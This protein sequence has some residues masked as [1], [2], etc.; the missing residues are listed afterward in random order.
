MVRY[1]FIKPKLKTDWQ[2]I[3]YD[4]EGRILLQAYNKSKQTNKHY[5]KM[6]EQYVQFIG[7]LNDQ[8]KSYF[9]QK[10]E[11]K[12]YIN[13][14]QDQLEDFY[15]QYDGVYDKYIQM[16]KQI[17]MYKHQNSTLLS[18][19]VDL[20]RLTPKDLDTLSTSLMA[21]FKKVIEQ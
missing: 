12:I 14:M 16:T 4:S 3:I 6:I 8:V 17:N 19:I 13:Q 7:T 1:N 20:D 2:D 5:L 9:T 11:A 21:G 10:E 18:L 15:E